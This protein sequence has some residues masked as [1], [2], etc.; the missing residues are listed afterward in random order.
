LLEK[1]EWRRVV[2]AIEDSLPLYDRVN[3]LISLGQA[4]RARLY[5]IKKLDLR[6]GIYVL[7]GGI[8]PGN[9]S[10]LILAKTHPE[11]LVGL[12]ESVR[13]LEAARA[14][15]SD[16]GIQAVELVRAVF[17]FLPFR[18]NLFDVIVTSYAL[19][20]CLDLSKSVYEYS[21][22]CR[23]HGQFAI[24]DIGKP[25]NPLTRAG[26]TLYMR[27]AV[28]AIAKIATL[29]KMRRNPWSKLFQTYSPL[30]TNQH[31]LRDVRRRFSNAE[32]RE[33]FMGG[34]IAV[35]CRKS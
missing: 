20:D 35:I 26:S 6:A 33:F 29:G 5:A 34:V 31:L 3:D 21:R 11:L 28:P 9:S 18:D 23:P 8:G 30:S 7:D 16:T 24:V 13:L 15:L 25:D 14:S 1:D 27:F 10:R 2:S 17:E 19:R 22:V 12:D 4:Q 32:L